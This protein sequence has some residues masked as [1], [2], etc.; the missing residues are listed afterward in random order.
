MNFAPIGVDMPSCT[1][2]VSIKVKQHNKTATIQLKQGRQI[3]VDGVEITKL[4]LKI[5]DGFLR[6]RFASSTMLLVAFRDGLKI[7]WDGMTR[8][9]KKITQ[10]M[11]CKPFILFNY[12]TTVDT[13][14]TFEINF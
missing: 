4:P 7:W 11:D 1:K 14:E 3:Q 9:V 12:I 8:L 13:T 6:I 5:F 2:S 10:L